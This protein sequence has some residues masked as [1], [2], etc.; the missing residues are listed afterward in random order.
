MEFGSS[1]LLCERDTE[2]EEIYTDDVTDGIASCAKEQAEA[3]LLEAA[4]QGGAG[5]K[6]RREKNTR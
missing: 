5:E 4:E 2:V 3:W 6:K 1:H